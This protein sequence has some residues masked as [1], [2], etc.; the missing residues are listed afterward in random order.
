LLPAT[1]NPAGV[2]IDGVEG[3]LAS[4]QR[5]AFT[6]GVR[7]HDVQLG[8]GPLTARVDVVESLGPDALV[9]LELAPERRLI[10]QVPEPCAVRPGDRVPLRFGKVHAFDRSTG[11]RLGES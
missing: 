5:G 4:S 9:H 2:V 11:V 1:G 6:L 8:D 3:V 7:P 10:A